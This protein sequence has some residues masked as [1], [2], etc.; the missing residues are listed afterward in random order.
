MTATAGGSYEAALQV[1]GVGD[2]RYLDTGWRVP[3]TGSSPNAA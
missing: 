1:S 2:H 3:E